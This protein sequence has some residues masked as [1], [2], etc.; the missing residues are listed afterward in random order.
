MLTALTR[1]PAP[2]LAQCELTFIER[3]PIDPVRAG[4]Q[5][6]AYCDALA[7]CGA[8]VAVLPA[9]AALPD[10]VFVE[11]PALVLDEVAVITAPGAASRQAEADLIAPVLAQYRP[12]V[13]IA[14]PATLEGGDVLAVGRTL[15]VG[16]SPRTNAAGVA[17]LA[18]AV[19]G[20]GYRVI[21][22][23][24]TGCLHLK[25]GCTALDDHTLL[26]NPAWVDLAPFVGFRMLTVADDEPFSANVLRVNGTL[27]VHAGHPRAAA[28][29]AQHGYPVRRVDIGE[30]ARAEAGL[31]CLSLVFDAAA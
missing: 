20:Y 12:L 11:D 14:P 8:R 15:Y 29:L 16:L 1:A 10:S 7:A 5:H 4:Q 24:V 26:A 30:F 31:T 19:A 13:R 18:A 3:L 27:L 6:Q 2:T 28:L 23:P 22:V 9:V 17:A 25:T 21:G